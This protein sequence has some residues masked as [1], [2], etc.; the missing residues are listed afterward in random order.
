MQNNYPYFLIIGGTR[1]GTTA[2]MSYLI[3]T[4]GN[5]VGLI[6]TQHPYGQ[7]IDFLNIWNSN[8][9]KWHEAFK[10]RGIGGNEGLIYFARFFIWNHPLGPEKIH[11]AFPNAKILLAMR[12]PTT[13]AFSK[14]TANKM[15]SGW[16]TLPFE[17]AIERPFDEKD[18][19][20]IQVF[21][22]KQGGYY[23]QHLKNWEK[24]YPKENIMTVH[25]ESLFSFTL[26][27]LRDIYSFLE[28][29]P[30]Q[31]LNEYEK[32]NAH[33]PWLYG[34]MEQETK[35]KLIDHF[36]PYNEALYDYLQEDFGWEHE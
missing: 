14:W 20:D 36:K 3:R 18:E 17:E 34:K 21:D 30:I 4:C 5:L 29:T 2:L 24:V 11:K 9:L 12:N 6:G 31:V 26:D 23:L 27:V 22:Y 28:I 19:I 8:S 10:K 33:K 7:A 25:S 32:I 35:S 15:V 1:C 13:R 16:E